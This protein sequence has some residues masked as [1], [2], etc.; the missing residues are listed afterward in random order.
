M[1]TPE[2]ME[3]RREAAREAI[4]RAKRTVEAVLASRARMAAVPRRLA[5]DAEGSDHSRAVF[6]DLTARRRGSRETDD[7]AADG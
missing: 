6:L 1:L 7:Q 4:E 3:A 5:A 2:E